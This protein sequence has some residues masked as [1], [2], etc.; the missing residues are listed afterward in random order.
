ME[1]YDEFSGEGILVKK[2]QLQKLLK[3]ARTDCK[4]QRYGQY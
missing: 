1:M 2:F 4:E 3:A